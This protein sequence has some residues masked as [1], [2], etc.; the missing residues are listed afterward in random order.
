MAVK[1]WLPLNGDTTTNNGLSAITAA[2]TDDTHTPTFAAGILG[3]RGFVSGTDTLNFKL[4]AIAK[5]SV[6]MWIKESSATANSVL[7]AIGDRECTKT[8]N[9]YEVSGLASGTL[10]ELAS[11]WNHV[12]ITA[13]GTKVEAYVNGVKSENSLNQVGSGIAANTTVYIG[14]TSSGDN[15]SGIISD[16]KICDHVMSQFEA[17][18]E[19]NALVVN[20]AFNGVTSL[21]SGVTLPAGTTASDWGFGNKEHDLSGNEYDANYGTAQPV[22]SSDTPLYS[23][24]MNM[25]SADAIVSP[26]IDT[27]EFTNRYTVS[28]WFKGSGSNIVKFSNSDNAIAASGTSGAWHNLVVTSANKQYIDGVEQDATQLKV[29]GTGN[30]TI[31]IGTN[32]TGLISDFRVYAKALSADEVLALYKRK[33][34]VDTSGQLIASEI[35]SLDSTETTGFSKKGVVSAPSI[36]NFSGTYKEGE[37]ENMASVT[38]FNINQTSGDINAVDVIEY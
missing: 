26:T 9:G 4:P 13:N 37:V 34:A 38:E 20:Y 25:S 35:V 17:V 28:V 22:S 18:A 16:F 21:G 1:V 29:I 23:A 24:S 33:A 7:F 2:I 32:Y 5:F 10:F 30:A 19:A 15:W 12:V 3:H 14:G 6:S 27:T 8:A 36:G 11:G 31:T